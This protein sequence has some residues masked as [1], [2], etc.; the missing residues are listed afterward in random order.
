MEHFTYEIGL[1]IGIEMLKD[2][3]L[4]KKR[5]YEIPKRN[6][7]CYII[8]IILIIDLYFMLNEYKY[9]EN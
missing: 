8:L 9:T 6:Y 4:V 7:F 2:D 5:N 3:V 1:N